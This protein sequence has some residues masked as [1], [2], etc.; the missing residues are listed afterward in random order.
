ML[1]ALSVPGTLRILSPSD[2]APRRG[3][4][5]LSE[6]DSAMKHLQTEIE[7]DA[8]AELIWKLILDFPAYPEWNPFIRSIG[9][10][11]SLGSKLAVQLQLP[12]SKPMAFRPDVL[13]LLPGRELRW[14]GRVLISGIFDGE[15]WFMIYPLAPDKVRFVQGER[16]S[17]VLAPFILPFL[18]KRTLEGFRRMNLA[19]KERGERMHRESSGTI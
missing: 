7:I 16:F 18:R 9:G 15:H 11:P 13:R 12:G 10:S 8:P 3:A 1:A 5:S 14:K 6:S 4:P 19:L 2:R 17:G